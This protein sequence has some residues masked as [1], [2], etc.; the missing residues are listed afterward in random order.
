MAFN[1]FSIKQV[2]SMLHKKEISAT[3]LAE[4]SLQKIAAVDK[5][6]KAFLTLNEEGAKAKAAQLDEEKKYEGKLAAIPGAIKDNIV[7]KGIRTTCASNML[8]NFNDPLY[9]ATIVEKLADAGSLMM[10]KVNLDEF[11]MGSSTETSAFQKTANP[12]NLGHVPG[13]SSGGSAAAVAAGEVMY[14]IGTD[15]GGSI[16]QPASFCGVV[17]MKPTYGLVSRY[18]M[19]AFAPSLD[20]AGPITKTVADNARVLEVIAGHDEKD[21]TS[22]RSKTPA[23]SETL[24]ADVKGLKIGVPKE[25]FGEGVSEEVQSAVQQAIAQLEKLGATW[26]EISLPY[27]AY[28][29]ATYYLIANSEGSSSLARFDGVRFGHRAE[30]DDMIEMFKQSR[31]EGF[32]EEVK[33]RIL[34]GTTILT[35]EM[36]ETYFRKA[37]KVRTL[38]KQDFQQ[39]FAKYDVIIGP[40]SP[41]T[42]FKF[43]EIRDPLTMYMSDMLTVPINLAGLPAISVPCGFSNTGLPIGLQI[44]GNHFA[45]ATIYNTAFAFEQATDYHKQRPNIGGAQ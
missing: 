39:A 31:S 28:G 18:G 4:Q 2:E 25:F 40:T 8:A 41:S 16:R 29:D 21:A 22:N 44:I 30:N 23:Y 36:N 34:M 19:V 11:A 20:Q 35:G 37:Q 1:D 6:V 3:E 5:D 33:R 12:W 32:G 7:T 9:D 27:L 10:G 45:E 15:T 42:A 13:G 43:G 17:G 14:A 24:Q 38:I 26:E